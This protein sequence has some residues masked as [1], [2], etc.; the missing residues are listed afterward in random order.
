MNFSKWVWF[1]HG[2]M[3]SLSL[4][5][6]YRGVLTFLSLG[7]ANKDGRRKAFVLFI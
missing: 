4:S 7:L 6:S 2:A 1:N 5:H 3:L